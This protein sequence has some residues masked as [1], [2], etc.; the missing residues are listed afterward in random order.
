[1][2]RSRITD[3]MFARIPTLLLEGMT[4]AQIA[5]MYGVS[6]G[7]LVAAI[8]QDALDNSTSTCSI[9]IPTYR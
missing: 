2:N 4:K 6:P 3:D 5:A 8:Q 7:T 1:M 9:S